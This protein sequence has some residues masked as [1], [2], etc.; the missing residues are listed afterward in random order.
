MRHPGLFFSLFFCLTA[1]V[2]AAEAP[3]HI[4]LFLAEGMDSRHLALGR[5]AALRSGYAWFP[6][7]LD[8]RNAPLA[9]PDSSG[10]GRIRTRDVDGTSTDTDA[11]ATAI[12]CGVK[13]KKG[14]LGAGPAQEKLMS[15]AFLAKNAGWKV[16]LLSTGP[17]NRGPSA[18]FFAHVTDGTKAGQI[19]LELHLNNIDFFGGETLA[20]SPLEQQIAMDA[21]KNHGYSVLHGAKDLISYNGSGKIFCRTSE[22]LSALERVSDKNSISLAG[23]V[24]SVL[25]LFGDQDSFFI[26]AEGSGIGGE[27]GPGDTA[28]LLAELDEFNEALGKAFDYEKKHPASTLILVVSTHA[29]GRMEFLQP[30]KE[31][32]KDQIELIRRQTLPLAAVLGELRRFAKDN[33][34]PEKADETFP[35]ILRVVQD[36]LGLTPAG[37]PPPI[38]EKLS[39]IW[40]KEPFDP[41]AFLKVLLAERDRMA[42]VRWLPAAQT[43]DETF[44]S[45]FGVGAPRFGG[46]YE[47]VEV[48]RKLS[49]LVFPSVREPEE[50]KTDNA[51]PGK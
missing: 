27:N 12:A 3:K 17:I 38:R 35:G 25:N 9:A 24:E 15:F 21:L 39:A 31:L 49:D 33:R 7:G 22:R 34:N 36:T 30:E 23:Q 28:A 14:H 44:V 16:A 47:N 13:T 37:L 46:A 8:E 41:E 42:G 43:T 11:A 2:G 10:S 20:G 1:L 29:S 18:A 19:A 40:A 4:F 32:T 5:Q 50:K 6:E 45:A 51:T 48:F 26:L